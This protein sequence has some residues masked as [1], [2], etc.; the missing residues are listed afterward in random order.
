[1]TAGP[2]DRL[3]ASG[4][5]DGVPALGELASR[6][7]GDRGAALATSAS[8]PLAPLLCRSLVRELRQNGVVAEADVEAVVEG[9]TRQRALL[10][11]LDATDELL[12]SAEFARLH[13]TRL[14]R[15]LL[16]A[17]DAAL[18]DRPL[19]A[20]A[21][22]E[23]A[24]RLALAGATSPARTSV[25]LTPED[26]DRLAADYLERLPRLIGAA[27]DAWGGQPAIAG[28]LRATLS[29]L[30]E[31]PATAADASFEQGM[32][33][34]RRAAGD[35]R[36]AALRL[37]GEA[38]RWFGLAEAAEEVRHDA[39]LYGAGIDVIMAFARVDGRALVVAER[40]LSEGLA[41]RMAWLEGTHLPAWRRPRMAAF[42]AWGR[43]TAILEKAH[44]AG[45]EHVW[46][47]AWPALEAVLDAY[48]L[49]RSVIPVAGELNSAGFARVV[50]PVIED[51]LVNREIL[52]AQIRRLTD[53][54][55]QATELPAR[56]AQLRALRYRLDQLVGRDGRSDGTRPELDD[57]N[58]LGRL[59]AL[60]P[61]LL[62]ELGPAD[63][64][65]LA[66]HLDD[67]HLRLVEGV[68]YNG[69]VRQAAMRDP[70]TAR[71][72]ERLSSGLQPCPD[73]RGVV[74]R[75]FDALCGETIAFVAARH[76]AKSSAG[77]DYLRPMKSPPHERVFQ[78]DYVDW[79]R[80]GPFAGRIDVEVPSVATG[81]ADVKVG[82]GTT[83]FFVE[84][85]RELRDASAEALE[86]SYLTQAADYAGSGAILGVLLVLDLTP[87]PRGVRHLSECAWVARSRPP[88]SKRDRYV[89]V[90]VV[91]GNRSSPSTYSVK[92]R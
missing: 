19:V 38:R 21:F 71:L 24:L 13:G 51:S 79:L 50:Q 49:N 22:A 90:A 69:T 52:L 63:A 81:R 57:R 16:A 88:G 28:T 33:A 10:A 48:V 40:R 70:V 2:L 55:A 68:A 27:L 58:E 20:S 36:P 31:M 8:G 45:A 66:A 1:M 11:T 60:A 86:R 53:E 42:S 44:R 78:D 5:E 72:L 80:R 39:A 37:L 59:V 64:A 4:L 26:P 56:A 23:G 18:A 30:A 54:L 3:L 43:L 82:A 76:D 47:N 87:H 15:A 34:L 41:G 65:D 91:A 6:L 74:R 61:S 9:L 35:S 89:V 14:A 62:A 32:D 75:Q 92:H 73:Y 7:I 84:V 46:L 12:E 85:K 83:A 29:A 25:M 77:V 67:D 17:H